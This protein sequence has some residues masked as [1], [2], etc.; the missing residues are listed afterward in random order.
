MEADCN[1]LRSYVIA[2]EMD[3]GVHYLIS[4]LGVG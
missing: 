2:A 3:T 1:F 4:D